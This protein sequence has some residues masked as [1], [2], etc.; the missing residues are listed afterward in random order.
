MLS[1]SQLY[2]PK[3]EFM[4]AISCIKTRM[5]IRKFRPEPVPMDVLR[6]VIETAK[7]SPSYKNSQPWEVMIVSGE[8]KEALTKFLVAMLERDAV[9]SPDLTHPLSWPAPIEE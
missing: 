1:S 9:S 6:E 2:A 3:E 7:W 8:K 4:D 5:S